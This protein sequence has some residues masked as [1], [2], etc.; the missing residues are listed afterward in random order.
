MAPD[1]SN[2]ATLSELNSMP[3]PQA[4]GLLMRA[5]GC[6]RWAVEVASQRPFDSI[7]SLQDAAARVWTAM[8]RNEWLEAF[9]HHP[10]IGDINPTGSKHS[11][12]ADLSRREQSGMAG[13]PD[14]VRLAFVELN[15]QY[16]AKFGH[17]FLICAGGKSAD[18]ML[19][20]LR[21]RLGDDA[22][23]ELKNAGAEQA[24]ITRLRLD[25]LIV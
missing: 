17:V 24:K 9:S 1:T 6:R 7:A 8:S 13:A 14:E 2:A 12:T 20:Q 16:E 21:A 18:Q 5:C 10:R 25:K 22:A 3:A 4:E 15:R 23:T 19:A 11:P